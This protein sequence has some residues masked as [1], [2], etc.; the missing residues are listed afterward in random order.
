LVRIRE[1]RSED[2]NELWRLDRECFPPRIAYSR[3]ELMHYIH[4]RDAFT[5]VAE[6]DGD[7]IGGFVVAEYR[8]GVRIHGEENTRATV[9]H[10]ITIDVA[11]WARRSGFGT[12][13]M[14]AAEDR[15]REHDCKAVYLETAVDNAAAIAFY[16][17]RGFSHLSTIPRYYDGKLDALL[18]GKRLGGKTQLVHPAPNAIEG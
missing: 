5:L 3:F 1:Y 8:R 18:M 2:F 15:L 7:R 10:I 12:I 4:R 9:G 14:D 13:L 16:N 6:A 11:P 17:R